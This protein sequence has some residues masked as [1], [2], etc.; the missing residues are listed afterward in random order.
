MVLQNLAANAKPEKMEKQG[1]GDIIAKVSKRTYSHAL[2]GKD[3]TASQPERRYYRH[4]H[5]F[6]GFA[7]INV[8]AIHAVAMAALFVRPWNVT[9]PAENTLFVSASSILFANATVYFALISGLLYATVLKGR[10]W[11]SF[12]KGKLLNVISPYIVVTL[13]LSLWVWPEPFGLIRI[14]PFEGSSGDF[15]RLFGW[16]IISG[17]SLVPMWYIPV[18][19][20]LFA[21]TPV[22]SAIVDKPRLRWLLVILVMLPLVISRNG[23]EVTPGSVIYFVGPYTLGIWM[24]SNYEDWLA[25]M[26]RRFVLLL[27]LA[28]LAT[29]AI[30]GLYLTGTDYVGPV[31]LDRSYS[32]VQK[33]ALSGVALVLLKRWEQQLPAWLDT[34]ATY[35]FAIYFLHGPLQL[36]LTAELG[37]VVTDYPGSFEVLAI[38]IAWIILPIAIVIAFSALLRRMFGKRARIL[39]GA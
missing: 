39:I 13:V 21:L 8:V 24:G 28:A 36:L 18:L 25:W 34:I 30:I 16:N 29:A 35:A 19:A 38:S 20:V 27:V 2:T 4:L 1:S 31:S 6:R 7:I 26:E 15:V 17:D 32:Y 33:L 14:A 23:W 11:G 10:S 3:M 22:L 5:A 9:V 12:F 37:R